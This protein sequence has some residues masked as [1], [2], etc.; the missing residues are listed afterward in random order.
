MAYA[1]AVTRRFS[2]AVDA[3]EWARRAVV[4]GCALALIGA[5]PILPL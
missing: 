2:L 5:G 4:V 3:A 1:I